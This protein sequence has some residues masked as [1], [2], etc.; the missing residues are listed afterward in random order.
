MNYLP[1][2]RT[3]EVFSRPI[4][5]EVFHF[6]SLIQKAIMKFLYGQRRNIKICTKPKR[7]E[8]RRIKETAEIQR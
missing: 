8:I 3:E 4:P 7:D 1:Q 5:K 2:E 6:Y